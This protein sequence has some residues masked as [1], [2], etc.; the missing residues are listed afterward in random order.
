MT[1]HEMD[2][3]MAELLRLMVLGAASQDDV[4]EYHNLVADRAKR[5]TPEYPAL[6][7]AA[8]SQETDR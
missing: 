4:S 5:M 8:L 6:R 3:R 7:R 1:E 2:R